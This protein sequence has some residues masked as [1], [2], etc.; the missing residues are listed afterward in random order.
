MNRGGQQKSRNSE[1]RRVQCKTWSLA[2]ENAN[3]DI[4]NSMDDI[5]VIL[6][7]NWQMEDE[8]DK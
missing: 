5:N 7:T 8:V 4:K 3:I 2:N 1:E 6:S